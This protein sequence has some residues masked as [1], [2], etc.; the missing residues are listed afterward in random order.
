MSRLCCLQV[1]SIFFVFQFPVFAHA[2]FI[3]DQ[4]DVHVHGASAG[5]VDGAV[6]PEMIPD[7]TAYRLYFI[8][9]SEPPNA[10]PEQKNR[11]LAHIRRTRL[12]NTDCE[13]LV[14]ALADF[15]TQYTDLIDRYNET[16]EA[17]TKAGV[18]PD[19][20]TFIQQREALV[21]ATRDN[22]TMVLSPDGVS[23]LDSHVQKEKKGMKISPTEVQ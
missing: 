12:T 1:L 9:V 10:A 17:A 14:G 6:H 13:A 21:Q 5:I 3:S 15:K 20:Q 7:S 8:A 4:I 22:L 18:Q 19:L 11:Q 23:R 2:Q 16:A